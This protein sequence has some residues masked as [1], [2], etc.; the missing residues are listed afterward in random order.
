M[1]KTG[2]LARDWQEIFSILQKEQIKLIFEFSVW[3]IVSL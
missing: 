1:L 3:L 2:D